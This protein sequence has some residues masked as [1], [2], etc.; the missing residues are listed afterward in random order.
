MFHIYKI[1][2]RERT[3]QKGMDVKEW[4]DEMGMQ[5]QIKVLAVAFNQRAAVEVIKSYLASGDA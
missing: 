5:W 2:V 3:D 4:Q 1:K